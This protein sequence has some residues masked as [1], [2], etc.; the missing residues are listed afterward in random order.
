MGKL[1]LTQTTPLLKKFGRASLHV[2]MEE[3][4]L[5]KKYNKPL[6]EVVSGNST[7]DVTRFINKANEL[8]DKYGTIKIFKEV[9]GFKRLWRFKRNGVEK[10]VTL[11][12]YGI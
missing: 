9:N 10:P 2:E 1:N 7:L 4:R 12:Y 3:I 8:F 5:S 6:Y 11:G